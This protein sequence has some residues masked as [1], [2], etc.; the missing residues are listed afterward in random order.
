[1]S[2]NVRRHNM[3]PHEVEDWAS[4]FIAFQQDPDRLRD[5]H[6][7]FWAAARFMLSGEYAIAEDCWETILVILSRQPPDSVIVVLAAGPLE[8]LI[9]YAGPQFIDRIESEARQNPAFRNLLGGVWE[10]STPEV[11]TRVEAARGGSW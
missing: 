9:H 5:G 8:D 2:S 10:C 4:A 3:A 7:L 1:M 11:W 6:P